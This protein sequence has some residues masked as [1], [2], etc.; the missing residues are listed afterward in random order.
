M[1]D[2]DYLR[3]TEIRLQDLLK[4]LPVPRTAYCAHLTHAD[5]V[6]E[7]GAAHGENQRAVLFNS[8]ISA[9][10]DVASCAFSAEN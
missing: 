7:T 8:E 9:S 4:I 10:Q 6:T 5:T 2:P 1:L 3:G